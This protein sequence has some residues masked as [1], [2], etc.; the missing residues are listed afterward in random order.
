MAVWIPA[1]IRGGTAQARSSTPLSRSNLWTSGSIIWDY[2][3]IDEQACAL[4]HLL[5]RASR[6]TPCPSAIRLHDDE[7]GDIS[8][9]CFLDADSANDEAS[10]HRVLYLG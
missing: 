9:R 10:Q 6:A 8:P 5:R 7:Y 3:V 1:P 2:I 4:G